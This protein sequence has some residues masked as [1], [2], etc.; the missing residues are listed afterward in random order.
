MTARLQQRRTSAAEIKL[1]A[2][3]RDVAS[4]VNV[5]VYTAQTGRPFMELHNNQPEAEA[6]NSRAPACS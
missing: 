5:T 2:A 6:E 1:H 3:V 4:Q